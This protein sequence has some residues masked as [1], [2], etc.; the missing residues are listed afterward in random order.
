MERSVRDAEQALL[1]MDVEQ[2]KQV[3]KNDKI[4]DRHEVDLEEECLKILALYQPVAKDLRAIIGILKINNDLERMGDLSRNI[5]EYV[6]EVSKGSPI[7]IPKKLFATMFLETRKMVRESLDALVRSDLKLA[8]EVCQNDNIVDDLNV[9]II[10]D[11]RDYIRE[12]PEQL[13][14]ALFL[15]SMS[16]NLERIADYATNIAEDVAY[17]VSGQIIRHVDLDNIAAFKTRDRVADSE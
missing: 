16:R 17:T 2:A 8:S 14:T 12:H 1:N 4:I 3:I 10:K 13:D 9:E 6:I 5:A 11:V 15:I 7:R